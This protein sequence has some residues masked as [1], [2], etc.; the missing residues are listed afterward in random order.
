MIDYESQVTSALED[1]LVGEDSRLIVD[2]TEVIRSSVEE[3][4]LVEFHLEG[5]VASP[6]GF[7]FVFP[8]SVPLEDS[9]T[10][11]RDF[12]NRNWEKAHLSPIVAAANRTMGAGGA[13]D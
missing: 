12:I 3:L 1:L 5:R 4:V 6:A 10:V 11:L 9:L 8:Q 2:S 7:N 13:A